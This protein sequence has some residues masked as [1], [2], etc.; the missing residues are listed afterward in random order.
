MKNYEL[1]RDMLGE[2]DCDV[3]DGDIPRREAYVLVDSGNY[4]AAL[5]CKRC[6]AEM[7]KV[8]SA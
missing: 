2:A 6:I 7:H 1:L 4:S 8:L 3:C 5:I